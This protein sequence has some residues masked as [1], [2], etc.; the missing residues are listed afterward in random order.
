R[1][2]LRLHPRLAPYKAAIFPLEQ[3]DGMPEIAQDLYR[4]LKREFFV[5]YDDDKNIGRR[6]RRHD[7]IGT[8]FCFTIDRDT[9]KDQTVT[10]RDRDTLAQRRIPLASV[11]DELHKLLEPAGI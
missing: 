11:S 6:Y 10:I 1:E 8:P 3:R 7:Q 2:F 5:Y 4:R 9:L